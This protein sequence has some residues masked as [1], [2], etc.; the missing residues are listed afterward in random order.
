MQVEFSGKDHFSDYVDVYVYKT[1]LLKIPQKAVFQTKNG[2][3]P[4][5]ET[6]GIYGTFIYIIPVIFIALLIFILI[7][8][9]DHKLTIAMMMMA[10]AL[11]QFI[12]YLYM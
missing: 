5:F 7:N 1:P 10:I 2:N 6:T 11:I 12:A 4:Y 8:N 3:Y 9:P